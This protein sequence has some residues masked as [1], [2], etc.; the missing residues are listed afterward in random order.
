[1]LL[2]EIGAPID[3]LQELVLIFHHR[4]VALELNQFS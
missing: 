1:M 4:G 3:Q 2:R